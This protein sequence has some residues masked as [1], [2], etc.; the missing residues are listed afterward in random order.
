MS[1][2]K[3]VEEMSRKYDVPKDLLSYV[4]KRVDYEKRTQERLEELVKND[5]LDLLEYQ[6]AVGEIISKSDL[7]DDYIIEWVKQAKGM[8]MNKKEIRQIAVLG[9]DDDVD[10]QSGRSKKDG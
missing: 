4:S 10:V 9:D 3:N 6:K 7:P 8:G 5:E 1:E 2:E